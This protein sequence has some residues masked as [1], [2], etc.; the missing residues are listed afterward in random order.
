MQLVAGQTSLFFIDLLLVLSQALLLLL[1]LLTQLL[2][3]LTAVQLFL[4][5]REYQ[6]HQCQAIVPL[7]WHSYVFNAVCWR[8]LFP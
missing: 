8:Q 7:Q 5:D 3:L 2:C 4:Y 1:Q 6:D